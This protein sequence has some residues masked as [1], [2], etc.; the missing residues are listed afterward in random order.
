M[1]PNAQVYIPPLIRWVS[2]G[3]D[4]IQDSNG[5]NAKKL[6]VPVFELLTYQLKLVYK[7][8]VMCLLRLTPSLL[9]T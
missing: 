7:G 3:Q 4:L 1:L 8:V 5:H 2:L 9:K 6:T